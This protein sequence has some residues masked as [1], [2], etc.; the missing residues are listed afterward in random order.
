MTAVL[1][2]S[3]ATGLMVTSFAARGGI[4]LAPALAVMPH[5]PTRYSNVPEKAAIAIRKMRRRQ[6]LPI[7]RLRWTGAEN[8]STTTSNSMAREAGSAADSE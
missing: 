5:S 8:Q 2:S 1:Q 4:D 3:T 7:I 6:R